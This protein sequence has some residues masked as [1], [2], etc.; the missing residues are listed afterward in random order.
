MNFIPFLKILLITHGLQIAYDYCRI[1]EAWLPWVCSMQLCMLKIKK[2][3]WY[4]S[5]NLCRS[6]TEGSIFLA[7]QS[8]HTQVH[9]SNRQV[10]L[11]DEAWSRSKCNREKLRSWNLHGVVAFLLWM[12]LYVF[13]HSSILQAISTKTWFTSAHLH[14]CLCFRLSW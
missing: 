9:L 2:T 12:E 13:E 4:Q 6:G 5:H 1:R 7:A 14:I 10:P 3:P 11:S 8:Y